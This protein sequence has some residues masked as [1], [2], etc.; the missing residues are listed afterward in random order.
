MTS[1]IKIYSIEKLSGD[2]N[3]SI[4]SIESFLPSPSIALYEF[5]YVKHSMDIEIKIDEEQSY[6]NSSSNLWNYVSIQNGT[7]SIFYYYITSMK[8]RG[9]STIL[10]SLHLDVLNS[11]KVGVDYQFT[12]KTMI[13]R[14]HKDR[15]RILDMG[16]RRIIDINAENINPQMTKFFEHELTQGDNRN[17]Y[18]VYRSR[19]EGGGG[20]S[21]PIDCLLCSDD[22]VTWRFQQSSTIGANDIPLGECSMILLKKTPVYA[23]KMYDSSD[24][25][26]GKLLFGEGGEY[27]NTKLV[28]GTES[29]AQLHIVQYMC[30][31]NRRDAME[32]DKVGYQTRAG[33]EH[34]CHHCQIVQCG[35][36]YNCGEE[37]YKENTIEDVE[38]YGAIPLGTYTDYL[39][40]SIKD[41]NRTDGDL[42]KI[43]KL[44]YLPSNVD[45]A[46]LEEQWVYSAFHKMP[47]LNDVNVPFLNVI[48]SDFNPLDDLAVD[49][50]ACHKSDLRD[51]HYE[52]KLYSSEFYS[53]K[54]V[55]DSFSYQFKLEEII[56]DVDLSSFD[57]N[58]YHTRT[59]HSS[60]MFQFP[61]CEER[62]YSTQDYDSLMIV[63]RN[64]E[65]PIYS[66]AF[67]NYIK[68]G[69]NYDVKNKNQQVGTSWGL[70]AINTLGAIISYA[71]AGATGGATLPAGIAL[72][73]SSIASLTSSINTTNSAE[74][75]MAQKIEQLR[76]QATS[77]SGSDDIDL[78]DAYSHNRA[79][80]VIYKP[81][82]LMEK[83]IFDLFFYTGYTCNY[84]GVPDL[85]S[86]S[87]F[88]FIQCDAKI[89]RESNKLS[90]EFRQELLDKYSQ[91]VTFIHSLDGAWDLEQK[92]ENYETI[93]EIGD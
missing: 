55:Y 91:G 18:L 75:N 69:Y 31:T 35:Y 78:L 85:T 21:Q 58:F 52:S 26:I 92:Y 49:L 14:E 13:L 51:E 90:E 73:T 74:R 5:Q 67:I 30:G 6:L 66:N 86:R 15:F 9:Q 22:K 93:L 54:F 17:W 44:P 53:I 4:D 24:N 40:D 42:V 70:F 83:R 63:N 7:E 34:I 39:C 89:D 79:K 28:R 1:T 60:M 10:L 12:D 43:L 45:G 27:Y 23:I 81:Y 37:M 87:R 71:V 64:N 59:L 88:N 61:K 77:V 76:N 56:N 50:S 46:F 3:F 11:F 38:S 25:L 41:I 84:Q 2:K 65:V 48:A 33:I 72:T 57:I 36:I 8:W 19:D 20:E 29:P 62:Y 32:F 16:W 47:I 80:F 82:P 68:T